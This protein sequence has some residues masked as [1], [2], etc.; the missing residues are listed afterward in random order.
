MASLS[1]D[2]LQTLIKY[3]PE[4][5]RLY[6]LPRDNKAFELVTGHSNTSMARVKAWNTR[7]ANKEAFT[8][9]LVTGYKVAN[10]NQ[11]IYYAH[12]VGWA[13]ATGTL[14]PAEID[15]INGDKADNR[16]V[17]LRSAS[18]EENSRNLKRAVNNTSGVTGV[19]FDKTRGLWSACIK[20]KSVVVNLGRFKQFESAVIARK[21]AEKALGF[22][23]NHGADR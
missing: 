1:V 12:R 3:D 11:Q 4:T 20:R 19:V 7:F 16:F 22:H 8:S 2:S 6:W 10:I 13:L 18:R 23:K 15:H 17:N 21:A 5:G 9:T 14:P